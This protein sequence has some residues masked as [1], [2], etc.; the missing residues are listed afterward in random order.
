MSRADWNVVA[1]GEPTI[2]HDGDE[3]FYVACCDCGLVHRIVCEVDG[4]HIVRRSW[5]DN[6]L[7]GA[8]RRLIANGRKVLEGGKWEL[9]RRRTKK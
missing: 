3:E 9:R 4:D 7:T 2:T 5:R 6:R 8:R 1:P